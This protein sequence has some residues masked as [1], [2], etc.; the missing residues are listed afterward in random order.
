MRV[1]GA[2]LAYSGKNVLRQ[3]SCPTLILVGAQ[4]KVTH[5]QAR[6]MGALIP[7]SV[8]E[9]VSRAHHFLNLDNEVE[10]NRVVMEFL[11]A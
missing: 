7:N 8:V 1:M 5:K 9:I 2:A 10:F 4:N 6:D 3:I 11:A